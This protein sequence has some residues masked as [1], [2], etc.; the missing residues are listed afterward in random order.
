MRHGVQARSAFIQDNL[1][2]IFTQ[3]PPPYGPY[4][5]G[6]KGGNSWYI[7]LNTARLY[8]AKYHLNIGVPMC[9]RFTMATNVEA[10]EERFHA[11][12]STELVVPTYNATPSQA[13]LT[14]LALQ[15]LTPENLR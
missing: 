4:R 8:S 2:R 14:I 10:L 15:P 11:R 13:Q 1:R 3:S 9:G 5:G 12:L 6:D 7:Y